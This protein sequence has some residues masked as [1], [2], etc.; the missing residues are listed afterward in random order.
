MTSPRFLTSTSAA[1]LA[2]VDDEAAQLRALWRR[3]VGGRW[4]FG[5]VRHPRRAKTVRVPFFR[6]LFAALPTAGRYA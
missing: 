4:F 5:I 3:Y 2:I 1:R 6:D